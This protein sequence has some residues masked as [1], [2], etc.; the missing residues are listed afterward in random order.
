MQGKRSD[1]SHVV[2]HCVEFLR[3]V[4]MC[5]SDVAIITYDWVEGHEVPYPDFN[6][7]HQ[8]RDFEKVLRWGKEHVVNVPVS[9]LGRLGDEV[10]L[11]EV[12]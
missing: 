1:Q 10:D 11:K 4:L 2:D 6:T 5:S 12:P 9:R 8:C 7:K 3:Q